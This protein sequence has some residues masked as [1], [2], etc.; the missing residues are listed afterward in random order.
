MRVVFVI[1]SISELHSKIELIKSVFGTDVLFV[2]KSEFIPLLKTYQIYPN[3]SYGKNASSVIHNM[4]LKTSVEDIVV[5]YSSLEFDKKLLNQFVNKIGNRQKVVNLV[6]SYNTFEKI[7]NK[8]YNAYVKTIFKA[9]D[10]MNSPKLQFLPYQFVIEL[11]SSHFGNR[12]FEISDEFKTDLFIEDKKTNSSSKVKYKTSK[13]LL[14]SIIISLVITIGLIL[15]LSF[16]KFGYLLGLLFV[17]LYLLDLF[18]SIIAIFKSKFD[19]R[20]L[21]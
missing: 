5:C 9:K 19:S 13:L 1:D 3:A 12:N 21:G 20:F 17:M 2:A 16:A 6:P 4:L 15:C 18:L 10:A 14:V 7:S 11:L 8:L